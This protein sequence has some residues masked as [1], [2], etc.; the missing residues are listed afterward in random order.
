MCFLSLQNFNVSILSNCVQARYLKIYTINS[1]D[2]YEFL[3]G[4][5]TLTHFQGERSL[6]LNEIHFLFLLNENIE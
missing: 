3:Q 1:N 4:S 6:K 5:F 2:F